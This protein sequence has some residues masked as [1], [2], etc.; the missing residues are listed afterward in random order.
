MREVIRGV[1]DVLRASGV[2]RGDTRGNDGEPFVLPDESENTREDAAY[3]ADERREP[4]RTEAR[5][6]EE[7]RGQRGERTEAGRV[8][9]RQGAQPSNQ[10][11]NEPRDESARLLRA[12]QR[13]ATGTMDQAATE[14]GDE[15]TLS[16]ETLTR[17]QALE[18]DRES[19]LEADSSEETEQRLLRQALNSGEGPRRADADGDED[20]SKSLQEIVA[21]R[22]RALST[23]TS[24]RA[25]TEQSSQASVAMGQSVKD[26]DLV[27]E[28]AAEAFDEAQANRDG[29]AETHS[30]D[31]AD[32][33]WSPPC[34]SCF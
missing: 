18:G 29:N 25:V 19:S 17:G 15:L 7:S 2:N 8:A 1:I 14:G 16:S 20:R 22:N 10:P 9:G 23:N 5:G 4:T 6:G 21:Q 31:H 34:P 32:V 3:A 33:A 24:Q 26:D 28:A 11:V 13:M 27:E 12:V 30:L